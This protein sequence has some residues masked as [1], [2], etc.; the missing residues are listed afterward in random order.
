MAGVL[1]R[2]LCYAALAYACGALVWLVWI[3]I[4]DIRKWGW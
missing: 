2:W 1:I 3:I 4:D